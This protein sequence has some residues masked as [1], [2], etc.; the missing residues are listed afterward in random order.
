MIANVNIITEDRIL[1][2]ISNS[3]SQ[4][5]SAG[6]LKVTKPITKMRV[7]ENQNTQTSKL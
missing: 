5:I 1:S 7:Q 3:E 4:N 6:N 2:S